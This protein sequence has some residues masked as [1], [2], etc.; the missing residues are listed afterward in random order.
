[1]LLHCI[2]LKFQGIILHTL[3][4]QVDN[5][6]YRHINDVLYNPRANI[7]NYIIDGKYIMQDDEIMLTFKEA[8]EYL[9]V[10]SSTIYR[11][12]ASGELKGHKVGTKWRF[13]KSDLKASVNPAMRATRNAATA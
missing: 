12:L 11:L 6:F 13:F 4:Y 9:R 2:P 10:S 3:T 1:M 7:V 5:D 8:K